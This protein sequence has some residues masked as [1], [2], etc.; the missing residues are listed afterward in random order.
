[1]SKVMKYGK[2][3]VK[4][5]PAVQKRARVYVPAVRQLASDVMYLKG[6]INSEPKN[7]IVQD[8]NN[9]TY[10]GTVVSLSAVGQGD[11]EN[12]RDGNRI[13]PKYLSINGYISITSATASTAPINA[14]YV[15]FRYWGESTSAAPS[16]TASEVLETTGTQFAPLSHL[17]SDNTAGRG[18]R[19]RR[20]EVHRSESFCLD[21]VANTSIPLNFNIQVNG[22]SKKIKEHIEFRSSVNEDPVSGGFYL[23]VISDNATSTELHYKIESKLTFYDN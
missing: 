8:S 13:L 2:Y 1:M 22:G 14:R 7:Y 23:L 10:S 3:A 18:D 6:L 20:I 4:K 16:V 9:F 5:Y 15:I 19:A 17:N 12:K 21:K 11:T